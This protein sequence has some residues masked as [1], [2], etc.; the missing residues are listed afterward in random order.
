MSYCVHCGVELNPAAKACPLCHTPVIDPNH[1]ELPETSP[2]FPTRPPVVEPVSR[3][4]L[5]FLLTVMLASA[6]IACSVLNLFLL[7][8]T[9]W[10]FY[11]SAAA[12]T[13]W[14]WFVLPLI[15][16]GIPMYLRLTIDV[17]AVGLYVYVVSIHLNGAEWFN[18]LALPII[19]LACAESFVVGYL[20]R[21]NRVSLLS[22]VTICIGA[23]GAFCVGIECC[24]DLYL[25]GNWEPGWSIIIVTICA[26]LI[27]PLIVIRRVPSLREEARRRFHL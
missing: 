19:L 14:V 6:A 1:L 9:G 24:V 16:H 27:V 20:L 17:F 21:E 11:V 23:G 22:A 8:D 25:T 13:L 3:H 5:A 26:A 18:G 4:E 2:Y 15:V 12:V 7:A 10:S